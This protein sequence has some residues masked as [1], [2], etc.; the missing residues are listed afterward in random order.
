MLLLAA[1]ALVVDVEASIGISSGIWQTFSSCFLSRFLLILGVVRVVPC[2]LL[3]FL[4]STLRVVGLLLLEPP[5]TLL[6]GILAHRK[7][8]NRADRRGVVSTSDLVCKQPVSI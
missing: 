5:A 2:I 1:L 6:D 3:L 4:A 7:L 8:A